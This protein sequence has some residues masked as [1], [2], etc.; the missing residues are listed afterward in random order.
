MTENVDALLS[1]MRAQA[2]EEKDAILAEAET[3]VR[4]IQKRA[5]AQIEKLKADAMREVDA[6]VCVES[7]RILGQAR[8]Y[9]RAKLLSAKR[10]LIKAAFDRAREELTTFCGTSEYGDALEALIREAVEAAAGDASIEVAAQDVD[11]CNA[12]LAK[13]GIEHHAQASGQPPGTVVA[14]SADGRRKIDNSLA[15]RLARAEAIMEQEV[16]ARLF[17]TSSNGSR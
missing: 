10:R 17:V 2:Q 9:K 6:Q 13:L 1:A 3:K 14:T 5:D 16:A 15:T 12:A 8:M 7:D 4:E 11:R